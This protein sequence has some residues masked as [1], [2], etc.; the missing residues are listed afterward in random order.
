MSTHAFSLKYLFDRWL[1]G[2]YVKIRSFSERLK[3]ME[4]NSTGVQK[5]RLAAILVADAVGFTSRVAQSE[6]SS[7]QA[8][9]SALDILTAHIE[10]HG[11]RTVK[12]M[13]DGLLA[14]FESVVNAVSAAAAFQR[15]LAKAP[16][17]G[18]DAQPFVFRIGIHLG[19]I[20]VQPDGDIL[21]N[22]VNIAARIEQQAAPGSV[23]ISS[24]V[25][26]QVRGKTSEDFE[27]IG[28]CTL[29]GI[30]H[31]VA[32]YAVRLP[33]AGNSR[34]NIQLALPDKPSI[35]VLPFA[36]MTSDG[37]Q[38][39][40]SDG[41]TEDLII[42]LSGAAALFV[43][44]RNSSF[45]YKGKSLDPFQ[46]RR[47][48]GVKYVLGGS[49]RKAGHSLRVTAELNDCETGRS[50]W[51]KR[52]DGKSDDIFDFQDQIVDAVVGAIVPYIQ[53]NETARA[54]SK[55]PD[56]LTAYEALLQATHALNAGATGDAVPLLDRAIE[57]AP[58]YAKA[59]ALRAWVNTVHTVWAGEDDDESIR[60]QAIELAKKA[61]VEGKAD[62]E[63]E[64][65][66]AYVLCFY[67]EDIETGF[68]ILRSVVDRCPNFVWALVSLAAQEAIRGSAETAMELCDQAERLNPKDPMA[69]RLLATR[70]LAS[71]AQCDWESLLEHATRT[72]SLMPNMW[73]MQAHRIVAL[74]QL[75]R[76]D[77]LQRAAETFKTQFPDF[78]LATHEE[79]L[80]KQKNLSGEPL[81]TWVASLRAA[82][83]QD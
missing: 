23:L 35:A 78:R 49:I 50:L 67:G 13:G 51:S 47:E 45:A 36:N 20:V 6:E 69:F 11:G 16:K 9:S 56:D 59:I 19:D 39:Y 22:G 42:G 77:D 8:A 3:Y 61:L 32:V 55:R 10:E 73:N 83:I 53:E 24:Q 60:A 38:E 66:A 27:D 71:W 63:V 4:A 68:K 17:D 1:C 76:A 74:T 64:G 48:L 80:S 31:P 2:R 79:R 29:K 34:A 81:T 57:H 65:Y 14:E 33:S 18:A 46:I 54:I 15:Y 30:D 52:L 82:G 72:L 37:E 70:A 5:R 40:F 41:L 12:T 21:G 7:L 44:A 62:P 28:L 75:R 25:Y 43:I 26:E 58:G